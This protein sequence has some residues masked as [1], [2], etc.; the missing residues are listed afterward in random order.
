MSHDLTVVR[1]THERWMSCT[2]GWNSDPVPYGHT[3]AHAGRA[4]VRHVME[5][6]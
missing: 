3:F 5:A 6:S 1:G 2:C 4:A